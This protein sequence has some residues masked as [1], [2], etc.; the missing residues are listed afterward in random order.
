MV[1]IYLGIGGNLGDRLK[2]ISAAIELIS[3][4]I[5]VPK[6]ISS[7]Y[8]SEPWGFFH[9][10]YFANAVVMVKSDKPVEEILNIIRDIEIEMKRQRNGVGYQGRTMD[11]DILFYGSEIIAT[12]TLTVPHPKITERLFVL[13]PMAEIAG[14]FEH[15]LMNK[16]ILELLHECNDKC[17]IRILKNADK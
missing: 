2:N 5:A 9:E 1:E 16:N 15:P 11:I 6:R 14:E 13:L 10:K 17:K 12:E 3:Q 4:K 8:L 7:V